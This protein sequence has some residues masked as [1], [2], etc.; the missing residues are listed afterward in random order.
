MACTPAQRPEVAGRS[1]GPREV[2]RRGEDDEGAAHPDGPYP[3][4][5]RAGDPPRSRRRR[6]SSSSGISG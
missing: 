6:S 2:S 1:A 4:G 5:A 3:D